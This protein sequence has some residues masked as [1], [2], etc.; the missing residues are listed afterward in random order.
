M[1]SS[2]KHIT[3]NKTAR[4]H[5]YG[6]FTEKTEKIWLVFHGYGQ[7]SRY[8]IKKFESLSPKENYVIAFEGLSKFYLEGFTGRIGATWMTADMRE[9]EIKD[10]LGY[11]N[12]VVAFEVGSNTDVKFNI[13]GFSQ[14]CHTACRWVFKNAISPS[15]LILWSGNV[16]VEYQD[17]STY[18]KSMP[19][20]MLV[21]N[22]DKLITAEHLKEMEKVKAHVPHLKFTL[23]DGGH[24]LNPAE[25]EK[26]FVTTTSAL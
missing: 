14:G 6:D 1:N 10:Y 15:N 17:Y 26:Q 21:G 4:Y 9:E 23:F 7:L 11:I 22:K 18:F 25:F 5:T 24:E 19:L 8:F 2:E 13:L 20:H 16:P 3:I 12:K